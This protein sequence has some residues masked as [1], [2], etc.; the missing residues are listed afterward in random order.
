MLLQKLVH[1]DNPIEKIQALKYIEEYSGHGN[2]IP[3]PIKECDVSEMLWHLNIYSPKYKGYVQGKLDGKWIS[4]TILFFDDKAYAFDARC[5][6]G[7][8]VKCYRIGCEHD[9]EETPNRVGRCYHTYK[10]KKCEQEKAY[11]S[12][13]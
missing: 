4:L 7:I 11:D 5:E 10:C 2:E 8:K 9:W 13:D 12:S 1:V 3:K 6:Y